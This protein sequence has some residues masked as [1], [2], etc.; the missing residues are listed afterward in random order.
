MEEFITTTQVAERLG[1]HRNSVTKMLSLHPELKPTRS[2]IPSGTLLWTEEDVQKVMR[3]RE[4]PSK[5][6]RPRKNAV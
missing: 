3:F 1:M 2:L 6:G 5:G 4:N